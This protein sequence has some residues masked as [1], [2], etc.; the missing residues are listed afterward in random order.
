MTTSENRNK[1][2]LKPDSFAVLENS[3]FVNSER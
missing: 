3:R 2:R 1:D